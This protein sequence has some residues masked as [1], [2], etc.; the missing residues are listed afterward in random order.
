MHHLL[1]LL[2]D[3]CTLC[4]LLLPPSK[5]PPYPVILS[6]SHPSTPSPSPFPFPLTFPFS[7]LSL[8][9]RRND[10]AW[11]SAM[12]PTHRAICQQGSRKRT[13]EGI[14]Q[15]MQW[16]LKGFS[17]WKK[18]REFALEEACLEGLLKRA[19]PEDLV[20]W[21]CLLQKCETVKGATICQY[22]WVRC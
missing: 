12:S 14:Q 16:A 7:S 5:S 2:L 22:E 21:L 20:M 19:N 10:G 17:D 9:I 15:P 3:L 4:S 1:S 11:H 8:H 18:A 13:A 6:P